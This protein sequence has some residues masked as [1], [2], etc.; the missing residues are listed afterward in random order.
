MPEDALTPPSLDLVRNEETFTDILALIS[1]SRRRALKVVNTALVELYWQI[2]EIISR[3]LDR[4]E[5][6]A[7][8]VEELAQLEP[9]RT[10]AANA[11]GPV[12]TNRLIAPKV[13]PLV[14]QTHPDLAG[15]SG[16][17]HARI[18]GVAAQPHG[19][20]FASRFLS[21]LKEFLIELGGDFCFIGSEFPI[22]W[23][24]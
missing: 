2:G 18:F 12:R 19:S 23:A 4:A 5:R 14:R 22:Q 21:K 24:A 9:S 6:G 11:N 13:S 20:R 15:S 10:R 3:K 1:S 7:G 16:F 8:V 17:L